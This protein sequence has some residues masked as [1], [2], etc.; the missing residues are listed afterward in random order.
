MLTKLKALLEQNDLTDLAKKARFQPK[1]ILQLLLFAAVFMIGNAVNGIIIGVPAGIIAAKKMTA[2]LTQ[3]Q[4]LQTDVFSLTTNITQSMYELTWFKALSLF[5]TVFTTAAAIIF[6]TRLEKRSAASMGFHKKNS[7]KKYL[8]GY[9]I[10]VI[11]LAVTCL[12]NRLF[13]GIRFTVSDGIVK[14]LPILLLMFA[15]YMLQG[16]SEEVLVRGYLQMTLSIHKKQCFAVLS[17]AFVF[18]ALH[19]FNPGISVLA[20]FNIFLFGVLMSLL[21]LRTNSIWFVSALHAAWNFAQ[22][23]LFGISVSGTGM[24]KETLLQSTF[25]AGKKLINGGDFGIEGGICTTIVL[26]IAIVAVILSVKS[27]EEPVTAQEENTVTA[28]SIS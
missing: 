14:M 15:G 3:S 26:V 21:L 18:A 13:G 28:E 17:S 8:L 5:G 27:K 22:G 10:G 19:L 2:L 7:V 9:V 6:C 23:H 1:T 4:Y 12:L 24:N 20:F 11:M 16:M 25:A